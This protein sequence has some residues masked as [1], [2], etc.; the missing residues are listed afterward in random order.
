MRNR[1]IRIVFNLALAVVVLSSFTPGFSQD[2]VGTS[3]ANFLGIAVGARGVA[4]GGAYT[5]VAGDATSIYWNP[6][7]VSRSEKSYANFVHTNW[8][9][10]TKFNWAGIVLNFGEASAVGLSFTSLDFGDEP[11]TTVFSPEG[12]GDFF[13]AQDIAAGITYARNLTDKFSIGGTLKFINQKIFNVS[14]SAVAVD[15]GLLFITHFHDIQLGVSFANLGSDMELS[16]KDL[17]QKVDLDPTA[18][19]NNES[20]VGLLKTESS[21][22]PV[23]F[24]VGVSGDLIRFRE[25]SRL[26]ISVEATQPNDNSGVVN[27]GAELTVNNMFFVRGGYKSLFRDE[28]E[29]GLTFGGGLLLNFKN[30]HSLIFDYAFADFGLLENVQM[31]SLGVTF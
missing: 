22:L 13:S 5:A 12:T 17:L 21:S 8:F 30:R 19:G 28:S 6:G 23:I 20:I 15:V 10:D 11:V 25:N 1:L 18:T 27:V 29:E 4:M 7:A 3:A 9:L 31:F 16:G 24:R 2:K 26:I 14:A